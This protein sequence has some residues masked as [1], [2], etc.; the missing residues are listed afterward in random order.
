M[1][2]V[3]YNGD[4]IDKSNFSFSIDNRAFKYGD[5]F[6]ET[7]RC[8]FGNP[9]FWEEH[10]FRMAGSFF[11]MKMDVPDSFDME[12][13]KIFIQTLLTKNHLS[14]QSARIRISFFRNGSGYYL[15][16]NHSVD[17]LIE[18]EALK[19]N[20][21]CLNKN[22]IKLGLYKDNTIMDNNL[23]RLKST[24]RLLNVLAAIYSRE[25]NYDECL[26]VNSQNN[27]VEAVSGNLFI[28][29]NDLIITPPLEDGCIDGVLR[30]VLMNEKKF[31]IQQKH[32]SFS[33][34]LNAQEIFITNVIS[35]VQWVSQFKNNIYK[36]NV[37]NKLLNFLNQ[38]FLV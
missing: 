33:D 27:I 8:S 6:F 29:V 31:N 17:F 34:L 28:I 7:I 21:Y 38:T 25:N 26:L 23:G 36:N 22:G 30:K 16:K 2:K 19:N 35:G 10:Y 11:M 5:A 24:N 4:Y 9:L 32:I 18:S 37:S 20:Y 14:D 13:F 3:C 12:N 15:P 1:D